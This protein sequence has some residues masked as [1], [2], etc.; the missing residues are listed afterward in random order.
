MKKIVLIFS[1]I[2]LIFL[3][4][5]KDDIS[6]NETSNSVLKSN[7][8]EPVSPEFVSTLP[9]YPAEALYLI[10][11]EYETFM[12]SSSLKSRTIYYGT[13]CISID[14][15]SLYQYTEIRLLTLYPETAYEGMVNDMIEEATS[16]SQAYNE[17]LENLSIWE[18]SQDIDNGYPDEN[19]EINSIDDLIDVMDITSEEETY[20]ESFDLLARDSNYATIE[21]INNLIGTNTPEGCSEKAFLGP[22]LYAAALTP[23]ADT[24]SVATILVCRKRALDKQIE[25][26]DPNDIKGDA[27][28]HVY[29][30]MLLRRY[31]TE[32]AAWFIMDVFWEN[33]S[34]NAPRDKY[35]DLHNNYVGRHS[36]YA[37]F[38]GDW[39]N[40]MYDW[41]LW[42]QRVR[43]YIF[44]ASSNGSLKTWTTSTPTSTIKSEESNTSKSRYIYYQ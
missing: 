24:Y 26:Y 40:D 37:L 7:E 14:S 34:Q 28:R 32:V 44:N 33:Y 12:D 41:G 42:G 6:K 22:F 36:K 2:G 23:L 39:A 9:A 31:L 8:E 5:N 19:D 16:A 17:Y 29:V 4:C 3:S 30:N 43:G 35:M 38:R 20:I 11:R 27:F 18:L 15:L 13:S 21:D 10:Q 1:L 25:Y